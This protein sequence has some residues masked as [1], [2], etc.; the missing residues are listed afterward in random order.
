MTFS[1]N[2]AKAN[3]VDLLRRNQNLELLKLLFFPT[4]LK[5]EY[6]LLFQTFLLSFTV[7]QHVYVLNNSRLYGLTVRVGER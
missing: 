1:I 4:N 3:F 7:T 5:V 2:Y 6:K